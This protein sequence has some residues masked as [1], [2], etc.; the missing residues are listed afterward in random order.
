[1]KIILPMAGYGTR[2]R[3]HTW[4]VPKPLVPLAG[5]A[6]IDHLEISV[7]DV[8]AS[9]RLFTAALAPLGYR[10]FV[11]GNPTGFGTD[12]VAPDFWLREGGPSTPRPHVAFNCLSRDQVRRCYEAAVAAG[13]RS[14]REPVLM[15]RVHQNYFAAQVLDLGG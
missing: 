10:R 9:E 5:K 7:A 6:M 1:M 11:A 13:A 8:S 15:P 14:H 3:P 2:L 12:P 4:H